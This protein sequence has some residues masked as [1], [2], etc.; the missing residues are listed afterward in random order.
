MNARK[1]DL[2]AKYEVLNTA[3]EHRV[4]DSLQP[5]PRQDVRDL[6]FPQDVIIP[7][8]PKAAHLEASLRANSRAVGELFAVCKAVCRVGA[9]SL[10]KRTYWSWGFSGGSSSS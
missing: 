6:C 10:L 5:R 1:T 3:R 8:L 4:D 7:S 2:C 9:C